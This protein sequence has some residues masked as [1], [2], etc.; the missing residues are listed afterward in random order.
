MV[1]VRLQDV[2]KRFGEVVAVDSVSL[3][4][5]KGELFFLLGP[6]GCG[7]STLLRSVAGFYDPD[8]GSVVFDDR[9]VTRVAPHLRNTGMVFQNYALWPHMTV[10]DNVGYGLE[11]RRIPKEERARR[12]RDALAM[13][14]MAEL[15]ARRP[16]Q[17]SGGQQQR[18]AL[19]RA[20]VIEPDV[21]LLDEPLSN[22]D[23]KLRLEMR[24]EIRRIHRETGI[25]TIYVTHDQKEALS[26]ADRV[27]VMDRGQIMQAGTPYEV[28]RRP[29]SLFVAQFIGETNL[30]PGK[31]AGRENGLL[32]V[33]TELGPIASAV[34]S[35][36]EDGAAVV[37][38]IRPEALEV[39]R[40]DP[41]TDGAVLR[42]TVNGLTYLGEIQQY[43]LG[44][45]GEPALRALELNPGQPPGKGDEVRLF[46][47]SED[48]V[49]FRSEQGA[50]S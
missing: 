46:V 7:K 11:V 30:I 44:G 24:D 28:Y 23:A 39:L 37:C 15:A 2:T 18:V 13:V 16:N 40:R 20:L 38:S 45:E 9:D 42:A 5:R 14:H 31:A 4:V 17:L 10:E 21:I 47:R 27:A 25:T 50:G 8:A 19:A 26:M 22:L 49:V 41:E 1:S 36:I 35:D 29:A 12:I 3:E 43:D 32:T 34:A 48:V 33:H 6:S